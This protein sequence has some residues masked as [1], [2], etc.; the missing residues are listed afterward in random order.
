MDEVQVCEI[1]IRQSM[2]EDGHMM[3]A[4]SREGDVSMSTWI[5]LLEL[6][7]DAMLRQYNEQTP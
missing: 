4:V 5:G 1:N 2:D 7:K 6:A 3:F